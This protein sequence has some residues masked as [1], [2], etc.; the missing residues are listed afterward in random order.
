MQLGICEPNSKQQGQENLRD[1]VTN[2]KN[3]SVSKVTDKFCMNPT[4][5]TVIATEQQCLE[6]LQ[7]NEGIPFRTISVYT[8]DKGVDQWPDLEE[9]VYKEKWCNEK[10]SI[11]GVAD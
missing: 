6:I 11:L 7:T 5:G 10:I 4:C 3:Q 2:P 8:Q 1:E 9:S